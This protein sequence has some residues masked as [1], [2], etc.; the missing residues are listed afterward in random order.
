MPPRS[1]TSGR[2]CLSL[3][4]S[5]RDHDHEPSAPDGSRVPGGIH[6]RPGH[7][8]SPPHP[9]EGGAY[10][11]AGSRQGLPKGLKLH[12]LVM[13][14]EVSQGG[15]AVGVARDQVAPVL[16][17]VDDKVPTAVAAPAAQTRGAGAVGGPASAQL[18]H[19]L[20]HTLPAQASVC[21]LSRGLRAAVQVGSRGVAPGPGEV[22]E[23]AQWGQGGPQRG[24]QI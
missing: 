13:A 2:C 11:G 10:P 23:P 20:Q 14:Y 1:R 24:R 18:P 15:V 7:P 5:N 21:P 9:G 16:Q 8:A 17:L 19:G 3:P 12:L 4:F 6:P 22:P